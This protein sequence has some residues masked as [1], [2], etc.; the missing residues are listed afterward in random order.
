MT[1][2]ENVRVPKPQYWTIFPNERFVSA[3]T[4]GHFLERFRS[5]DPLAN[6][7]K[8]SA[9]QALS[10]LVSMAGRW[11]VRAYDVRIGSFP[12]FKILEMAITS[13]WLRHKYESQTKFLQRQFQIFF[14]NII[15]IYLQ[16]Y[17]QYKI[18]IIRDRWTRTPVSADNRVRSCPRTR[19]RTR[20]SK[21]SWS[22]TRTR[23]RT[24]FFCNRGHGRGHDYLLF[25]KV[26][27]MET[28]VLMS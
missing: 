16:C 9:A 24:P 18:F 8:I 12:N 22:R 7:T 17:V 10:S 5:I 4:S 1:K 21:K 28:K 19:T 20:T 23:T 11:L 6:L 27:F 26:L 25:Q 13:L 2:R 3:V 14:S 15:P